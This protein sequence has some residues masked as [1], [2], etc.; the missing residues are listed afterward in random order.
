MVVQTDQ[1][2]LQKSPENI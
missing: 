2:N 1:D